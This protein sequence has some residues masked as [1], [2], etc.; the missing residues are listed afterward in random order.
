MMGYMYK[1]SRFTAKTSVLFVGELINIHL[2]K[3]SV[4]DFANR[5][6]AH[7]IL[8]EA[9]HRTAFSKDS[10]CLLNF[11]T[12][13][14]AP[15]KEAID[16]FKTSISKFRFFSKRT[17]IERTFGRTLVCMSHDMKAMARNPYQ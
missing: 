6:Y 12:A 5:N 17:F 9:N 14:R 1:K 16:L 13:Y 11:Q 15:K 3:C 2:L 10:H 7:F 8:R 4:S